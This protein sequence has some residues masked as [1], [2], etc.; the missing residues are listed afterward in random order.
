MVEALDKQH[1]TERALL[2][3]YQQSPSQLVSLFF[4]CGSS[5]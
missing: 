2:E 5:R 3:H 4:R 1:A